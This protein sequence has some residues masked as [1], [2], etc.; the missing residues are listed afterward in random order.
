[1]AALSAP[2]TS[3]NG[4]V[5]KPAERLN[6][7]LSMPSGMGR[8]MSKVRD[9]MARLEE[10]PSQMDET[11]DDAWWGRIIQDREDAV[12]EIKRLVRSRNK[13]A[14]RYNALLAKAR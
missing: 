10:M 12:A 11:N 5:L 8:K 9:L 13:W 4:A 7:P 1:M 3:A 14:Q 6:A 2:H